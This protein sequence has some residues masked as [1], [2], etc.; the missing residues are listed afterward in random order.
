[1]K[2]LKRF[3]ML[4]SDYT[5]KFYSKWILDININAKKNHAASKKP[6]TKDYIVCDSIY[7]ILW[8]KQNCSDRNQIS[9]YPGPEVG[10]QI[11]SKGRKLRDE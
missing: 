1:M 7:M 11:D 5:K 9:S 8:N 3:L 6:E 10:V 2:E 4:S